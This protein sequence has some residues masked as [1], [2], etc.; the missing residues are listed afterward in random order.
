MNVKELLDDIKLQNQRHEHDV[1]QLE[2]QQQ[3]VDT[4]EHEIVCL[5]EAMSVVTQIAETIQQRAHS[6]IASVVSTA[7]DTVFDEPYEFNIRFERRRDRTEAHLE[8]VRDGEGVDPMTAAG[9]GVVDVAS[10]ALRLA[11]LVLQAPSLRRVLVLDEPFRFVS[12]N[13][14]SRL[15]SLLTGL[16]ETMNVQFVMVTHIEEL[17]IGKVVRL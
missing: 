13:Y 9:G 3:K 14:R 5:E 10:F 1:Q 17:E 2:A 15:S 11:C 6:R 16:S 12:A 8:F 7:L 4:I